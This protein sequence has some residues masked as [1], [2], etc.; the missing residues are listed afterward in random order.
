MVSNLLI[1]FSLQ[2]CSVYSWAAMSVQKT[3]K[4]LKD[5]RKHLAQKLGDV[6]RK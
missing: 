4:R 6:R 1:A 5:V 2:L 3:K